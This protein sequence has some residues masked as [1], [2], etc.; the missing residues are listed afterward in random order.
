MGGSCKKSPDS[1]S[2]KPPQGRPSLRNLGKQK[3]KFEKCMLK[4]KI[5]TFFFYFLFFTDKPKKKKEEKEKT[6]EEKK[7]TLTI[8][9]LNLI[10]P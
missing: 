7:E 4:W 6:K 10:N 5:F 3:M 8:V 1:N 2:C 9:L